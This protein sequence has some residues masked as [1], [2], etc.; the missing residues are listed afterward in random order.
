MRLVSGKIPVIAQEITA[1]LCADG[2]IEVLVEEKG[3]VELDLSA[4][5]KE[6]IRTERELV[7]QA[8]DILA[9]ENL[10]FGSLSKVKR[11]LAES[12]NFGIGEDAIEYLVQQIIEVLLHS[13]HVEEVYADD[14]T[15]RRKMS[16]SLRKHMA[17]D[18]ELD[19]EVRRRIKN[20]QEGSTTWEVDY[21][22]V[23]EEL[24]RTHRK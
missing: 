16:E 10:D 15:L 18:N 5:L 20:L 12:R 8:R 2:D 17:L 13:R 22:R 6:Y 9:R 14:N 4:V 23:M 21:Q 7:D 19:Q 24:R 11:R 3:E 1:T